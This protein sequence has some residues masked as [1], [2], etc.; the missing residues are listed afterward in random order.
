[1]LRTVSAIF[2]IVL[3]SDVRTQFYD[4]FSAF[5]PSHPTLRPF[6]FD[7]TTKRPRTDQRTTSKHRT[8]APFQFDELDRDGDKQ[9]HKQNS[10]IIFGASH[11]TTVKPLK[12]ATTRSS[13]SYDINSNREAS[14]N[15][16]PKERV[17]SAIKPNKRPVIDNARTANSRTYSYSEALQAANRDT[18]NERI[19]FEDGKRNTIINYETS[20]QGYTTKSYYQDYD[21]RKYP[22]AYHTTQ[23]PFTIRPGVKPAVVS[24]P[25]ITNKPPTQRPSFGPKPIPDDTT[26][27]PELIIGPNE[28]F[29]STVEKKRYIEMAEKMCDKYKALDITQIQAIPLVPSPDVVRVNVSSCTP[30]TVPLVV[31]G[32]VVTVKEFPHMALLG[33]PKLRFGGYSWKC[34]GSLVSNRYVLTA[35]HCVYQE[36]DNTVVSGAPRAVQLGSSYLDDPTAVVVK[37]AAVI[38]HPKYKLPKSYYDLAIVKMASTVSF[39]NV[40]RPACLGIPPP[41]GEPIIASGWGR[42]E[43]GGEQSQELRSVSVPV[44]EMSECY[45]VLGTSRKIPNGPSSDSQICAGEKRGGKDTCQGDSGGP[46]QI[47]DGCIWRVVAVTSLGRSCGAPHTPALYALV[48][49]AFISAVVFGEQVQNKPS[50]T[51]SNQQSNNNQWNNQQYNGNQQTTTERNRNQQTNNNQWNNQ[52]WNVNQQTTTERNRNQQTNNN[53]WNNQQWNG[54]QQTTTEWNRNQQN[55]GQ[56]SNN[57]RNEQNN[58][59]IYQ[60]NNGNQ[61]SYQNSNGQYNNKRGTTIRTV[62]DRP[63][64]HYSDYEDDR[65]PDYQADG[66]PYYNGGRAW[67]T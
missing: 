25:P 41:P 58:G 46:A 56:S 42:T 13:Q 5:Q 12:K 38:R 19:T 7:V 10:Q 52:Q 8:A 21:S 45:S 67:W 59:N 4:F 2:L 50:S 57:R 22:N 18:F 23:Y 47:Q 65:I 61:Q 9:K 17:V 20:R 66:N 15:K 51:N 34:G 36:R 43:F 32:K 11:V 49:R 54:N 16:T 27:S 60:S 31:G 14:R 26:V 53:Q 3:I 37:V 30:T 64:N 24:G 29:M 6:Q 35:A 48:Q 62:Y 55:T 1:M 28:D 33:W 44:W 40:I 63:E 39:S